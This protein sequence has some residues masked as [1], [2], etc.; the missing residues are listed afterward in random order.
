MGV[1]LETVA[2]NAACNAVVD[3]CDAGSGAGKLQIKTSAGTS[4]FDNGRVATLTFSDPAFGNASTGVATASAITSDTNAAAGTAAKAY[5]YDSDNTPILSCAVG[6]S[7]SDIN[8][9]SVSIGSGD[10][11]SI[12]SLTVTMPAS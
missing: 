8:L 7:G 9:S 5:F 2:R 11:V 4:T 1:T 3:L 10:T 6:T 12:S